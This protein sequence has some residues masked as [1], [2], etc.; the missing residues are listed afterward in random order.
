L[1]K[2]D[3]INRFFHEHP[4]CEYDVR[5]KLGLTLKP[6]GRGVFRQAYR[7]NRLPLIAKFPVKDNYLGGLKHNIA[8]FAIIQEILGDDKLY[9]HFGKYV[10]Q[11]YYS[12]KS[13]CVLLMDEYTPIKNYTRRKDYRELKK[14]LPLLSKQYD[15]DDGQFCVDDKGQLKVIDWGFV[16]DDEYFE[17]WNKLGYKRLDE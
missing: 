2:E 8:E 14:H 9:K 4:T 7:V 12:T 13:G 16:G 5:S 11:F 15:L 3:V 10:P 1:T 6:V 17:W